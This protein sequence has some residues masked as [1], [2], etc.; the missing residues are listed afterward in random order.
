MSE[1]PKTRNWNWFKDKFAE[2]CINMLVAGILLLISGAILVSATNEYRREK[3]FT[4]ID[5]KI[6]KK[7]S[8]TI[9]REGQLLE[10][11]S[12]DVVSLRQEIETLKNNLAQ[13]QQKIEALLAK[14]TPVN[15][16][17]PITP[18]PT[19]QPTSAS[20]N[21]ISTQPTITPSQKRQNWVNSYS[22]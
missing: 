22:K 14:Q 20:H 7:I 13:N 12:S 18:S 2:I 3:D 11:V 17:T 10:D 15:P 8:D 16:I 19:P 21:T 6:D 9:N 4:I 5:N 1:A